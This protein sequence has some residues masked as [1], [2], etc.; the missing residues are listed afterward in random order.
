MAYFESF[1]FLSSFYCA[2]IVYSDTTAIVLGTLMLARHVTMP[3]NILVVGGGVCGPAFVHLFQNADQRHNITVI[4][5]FPSLRTSGLQLDLKWH[6]TLIVRKMGLLDEVKKYHVDETGM[7]IVDPNGKGLAQFGVNS[8]DKRQRIGLTVEHEI[9]RGDLVKVFYE[10][11]LKQRAEADARGEK[12]GSLKYEFGKTVTTLSQSDDAVDVTFSDGEKRRFDL[13]VAADGQASRTRRLAF[14]E[15]TSKEVVHSIN[16][17]AAYYTIP[18]V[19][20]EG[21]MAKGYIPTGGRGVM[22]RNGNRPMTQIYFFAWEKAAETLKNSYKEPIEKQKE[23]WAEQLKDGGWDCE[24]FARGVHTCDDFYAVELAQI[25][26]KQ[27]YTGRVV[28]VGDAGFAP[29]P[30]TGMGTTASLIG[31]YVLAGELVRQKGDVKGALKSYDDVMQKPVEECQKL[32]FG[33]TKSLPTSSLALW[34]IRNALWTMST[35]RIDKVIQRLMDGGGNGEKNL[36]PLPE[37]P[38]LKL[39]S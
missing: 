36:W 3:L 28:L 24:R 17:H 25:K 27:L 2:V 1:I 9:M 5:R 30:F 14:G 38:E 13:V 19:E 37:Y 11:S 4:E 33:S 34:L 22:V 21:T 6:G 35:L 20:G 39:A 16:V 18:R 15:Q 12:E 8:S 7:E 10:G 26:M 23:L 32:N 31:A 29:T